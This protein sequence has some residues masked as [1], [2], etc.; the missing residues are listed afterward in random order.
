[1]SSVTSRIIPG[2]FKKYCF[3]KQERGLGVSSVVEHLPG[4]LKTTGSILSIVENKTDIIP[5]KQNQTIFFL[6]L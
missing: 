1:M 2:N 4:M 5:T 3:E 6:N